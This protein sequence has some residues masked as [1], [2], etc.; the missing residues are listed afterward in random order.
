MFSR[1][2]AASIGG[3]SSL[4]ERGAKLGGL[5]TS[6]KQEPGESSSSSAAHSHSLCDFR[7]IVP[8]LLASLSPTGHTP[9]KPKVPSSLTI[10]EFRVSDS[11][12]EWSPRTTS[13]VEV[14]EKERKSVKASW[15][16]GH[17]NNKLRDYQL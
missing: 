1:A 17:E 8:S 16:Q 4:L 10:L 11:G 12:L 5:N 15:R 6:G 3:A 2:L 7:Y 13:R 9:T 14:L